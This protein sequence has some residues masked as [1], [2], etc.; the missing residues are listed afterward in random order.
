VN[1]AGCALKPG[2]TKAAARW[3]TRH[4]YEEE[5]DRLAARMEAH[6]EMMKRRAAL[7]E[8]PF[9]I[10]KAMMGYPRFLCRG[11]KAVTAEMNLCV[12]AFNLKRAI[13]ILGTAEL[14]KRLAPA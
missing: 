1:C 10:L 3:V 4:L 7:A 13:A 11:L 5:L 12:L 6:P 14:L 2:C 9:G 8:H